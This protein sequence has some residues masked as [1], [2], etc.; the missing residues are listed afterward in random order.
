MDA[1]TCDQHDLPHGTVFARDDK[2]S[3]A[4]VV[5]T[6]RTLVTSH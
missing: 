5:V 4:V 1:A 2:S 3:E 6:N